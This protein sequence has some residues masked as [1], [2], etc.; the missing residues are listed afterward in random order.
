MKVPDHPEHLRSESVIIDGEL[1]PIVKLEVLPGKQS[2]ISQLKFNWTLVEFQV[3]QLLIQL[4]FEN[5]NYV[6]CHNSDRDQI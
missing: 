2:D 4:D 3:S 6:S 1:Y 5:L